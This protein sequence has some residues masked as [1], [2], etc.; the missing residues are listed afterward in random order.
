MTQ[1]PNRPCPTCGT[2]VP[3]GQRFC[4]NCGTAME[5]VQASYQAPNSYAQVPQNY[6]QP[7]QQQQVPP[8]AQQRQQV[9]PYA[10]QPQQRQS[11][12]AEALGALGLLFLFRRAGRRYGYASGQRRQ[13]SGC[14]AS[15][16]CLV[17]L[18]ILAIPAFLFVRVHGIS[19]LSTLFNSGSN[20]SGLTKQPAI[21]TVQINSKVT[22]AS[23]DI[24]ILK[25]QQSLAFLDDDLTNTNGMVRLNIRENS[26]ASGGNYYYGDIAKLILPDKTSVA[27][28]N[29]QYSNS[30]DRGVARANWLDFPV[31]ISDK[32]SELILQL[33]KDSEAQMNISLTGNADLKQYEPKTVTSNVTTQYAGLT[34]TVTS[35]TLAWSDHGQQAPKGMRYVTVTLKI[36]NPSSTG[37]NRYW[38][39]YIRLKSGDTTSP[40]TTDTTIPLG[41]PAGSSGMTGKAIF[42]MPQEST[43]YTLILLANADLQISQGSVDFQIR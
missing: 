15:I 30:P 4:S 22:Y 27:P 29:A 40:P 14:C 41:V 6:Q 19:N 8:Y 32:I 31:P 7:Q 25:A 43:S 3:V 33:G 12:I 23:V 34:W 17:L 42:L 18:A 26:S 37:F 28:V 13:S 9:P 38:G 20:N 21:T 5:G 35:A 10:Q 24:T 39:D 36:N 1:T 16:G 2:L 11:P